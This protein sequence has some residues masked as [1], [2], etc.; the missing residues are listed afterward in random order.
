[1]I[2]TAV[3]RMFNNQFDSKSAATAVRCIV[4]IVAIMLFGSAFPACGQ[5]AN[6]GTIAGNISDAQGNAVVTAVATLTSTTQ[7]TKFTA[8]ANGKGEYLLT[9]IPVGTYTLTV[10]APSFQS[11]VIDSIAVD[12]EQD[13]RLDAHLSSGS[14]SETVTVEA[15]G[16]TVDTR[17][18]TIATVIDPTLVSDTPI[19]GGNVVALAALLPGVTGVNAPTT[20]TS[21][22]GGPTYNVSGSRSNQNLFLF[23]GALWNNVYFNTGLNFP[24]PFMLEEVSVQLNNFKAQYGRNVG[25]VFNAL[26]KRGSNLIHGDV[27]DYFNNRALNAADYISHRNPQLV[28]NQYGATVGGPI[29][30]DK[31][32][33]FLGF[34][35]LH[36]NTEV[37]GKSETPTLA[38]RGLS[39]S[40]V[41]RPCI[42]TQFAGMTCASFNED[43]KLPPGAGITTPTSLNS[44]RNPF[45]ASSTYLGSAQSEIASTWAAQGGTGNGPCY[46]LLQSLAAVTATKEYL[47]NN[48]I[49]SICFNPV[50]VN[51]LAKYL[52]L[53]NNPNG[54]NLPFTLTYARSP[55]REYDGFARFDW[56]L[57]RHTIDARTFDTN[58]S[59]VV[60]NGFSATL[61]VTT[62]DLDENDANIRSGNICDTWVLTP[63]L[64]NV[65]RVGYK[66]YGYNTSPTDHTTLI[67]LGAN[68]TNPGLP[69]LPR[70]EVTNR[71]T[72][73]GPT[74]SY[75]ISTNSS[76]EAD[77]NIS[78]TRGAHNLQFGAQYLDLN[79]IHRFDTQPFLESETQNTEVGTADFLL[80]LTY[81]ET[82]AN[83]TNISAIEHAGY[84]FAQDDWRATPRL[85]LNLGM[86][87]ELPK[88]WYQPDGQSVTFIPGYQST[89]FPNT[90]SSLAYQNDPGVPNSIIKTNYTNLAPRFG[91]AYDVF[92]NGKTAIRAGFG[93]FYDTLNANTVGIGEPYHYSATYTQPAGSFSVPLLGEN[94]IPASYTGPASA[95]F[96]QPYTVNFADANVTEPYTEAMNFGIQQHI[97]QGTLELIYISKLGRHGIVPYDLNPAIYDCTGSYYQANPNIYCNSAAANAT[98]YLQRVKYP[99]FNYGGQGIVDNNTIGSSNYNGL[100]VI[101]TQRSKKSLST[102][103]SYT[104]SRSL[105]DQSSGTTNTA[106]VPL[107]PDVRTNYGPSDFQ[108]TH[109][110]NAGWILRLPAPL[111]GPLVERQILSGWTFGG[112]FNAKTG[113]P[114]N[115]T[116]AGDQSGTDERP[117]RPSLN[118]GYTINDVKLPS[119]RHRVE[120]V[121]EWFNVPQFA[122]PGVQALT[123]CGTIGPL[124]PCPGLGYTGAISRNALYGPAFIETDM[125][126]RKQIPLR[127]TS[128]SLLD[129]RLEAF[130]VF[131]T[132]NLGPPGL[133]NSDVASTS[134]NN[135]AGQIIT[136][137]GK[138]PFSNSNGRRVQLVMVFHY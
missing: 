127:L 73:G 119:N 7:G 18:A 36:A 100:Q 137:V 129:L 6:S 66:R 69:E 107:T 68:V 12:A 56:N 114:I 94:Q 133:S 37:D 3:L 87:Y 104:Y 11:Y 65:L 57:G 53:P 82:F 111:T 15:L 62:Y 58:P 52:P 4:C 117:Q 70:M 21:D 88:P 93:I 136:T 90:P 40:G 49:P 116:L 128:A 85:T 113:S 47:P 77:E 59:D 71:F 80:G 86:R 19:D 110:V 122:P 17:S 130:N 22:T 92:G 45:Y 14:V 54:L 8:K 126:L 9:G 132:P 20:F 96:T 120:K 35:T 75:S 83:N 26:T 30:R 118:P 5:A 27:W 41:P 125:N 50:A 23:D 124:N 98:S 91:L 109:V 79:Y 2:F 123:A 84:F 95:Q 106:A 76:F 78:W 60:A 33:F 1:M 34:Q 131:N 51:F 89:R 13:V 101:Y 42:S 103:I 48:E 99:G 43:F 81:M 46:A 67:D 24:P 134:G 105:D 135:A 44:A 25:S 63:N 121:A 72:A 28:S 64:L 115:I 39:A 74:S 29:I 16:T 108:A 38:E 102:V 97:D 112:I 61:P 31:L 138:N 32:F 55:K 10:Q